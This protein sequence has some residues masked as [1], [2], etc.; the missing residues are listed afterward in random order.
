MS[1]DKW[2][3]QYDDDQNIEYWRNQKTGE[4]RA[5]IRDGPPLTSIPADKIPSTPLQGPPKE[6]KQKAR[7][8]AWPSHF[9]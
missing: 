2:I 8:S 3:F 7:L 4:V 5:V 1:K 6:E 9:R